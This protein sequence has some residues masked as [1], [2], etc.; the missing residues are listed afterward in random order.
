[1]NGFGLAVRLAR[2]ELRGGLRSG[3]R[4]FRIFIAC[5]ALGVAAIA[6]VGSIS[7][8]VVEG[9]RADARTLLGGDVELR[10]QHRAATAEQLAYLRDHSTELST[11]VRMR[12]MARPV[13]GVDSRA[14]VELK[15]VDAAYP[16]T[17][18]LQTDP[19][20]ERSD[21]LGRR[22]GV[23]GVAV[24]ANLL[25][26][27]GIERGAHLR[28]GEAEFEV[29]A[30]ITREPDRVASVIAFGPRALIAAAALADT[31]LVQPGSQIRY[32]YRLALA[33]ET[34]VSAWIET[35]KTAYPQAGWRIRG[36]DDAAPGVRRFIRRLTLFLTFVGLSTL[37]VGGIGV[38]NA[39]KSYLDGKT[40][41]IATLKCLGAPGRLVFAIYMLQIMGL[42]ALGI[43]AGLVFG[44]TAPVLAMEALSGLL[45]VQP[46]GGIFAVP[47]ILAAGFGVLTAATFA[48]WP[49]ARA[50]EIPA[51]N[52]FRAFI[53]PLEG[54]PRLPYMVTVFAGAAL[55]AAL[56]VGTASDV[57]SAL[58]FVGGAAATFAV[59]RLAAGGV[60]R[61]AARMPRPRGA[62]WRLALS[63][64][65]RP[66]TSTPATVVSLG[67]GLAVLVAVVLIE[68]N[69]TRQV[70]ERLPKE[71]P[72]LFF[73]D[74]QPH[75]VDT[76]DETVTGSEGASNYRRVPSLRGRIIRI[77]GVAV[78]D[79]KV[80]PESRW[81]V[82]GDRALTYAATPTKE[83][84][85]IAGKW[86][87]ADYS[88]P[89]II[90][91]DAGL[92]RGFGVG[93]GDKLAFNIL[94]REIEAEIVS[95]REIDWRSL[96]FDFAVIF[97]PGSLEG[98][99]HTHIAAVHGSPET[100][101]RIEKAV[102]DKYSNVSSIRVREALEA[103]SNILAGIGVA[104]RATASVTV[105]AGGLVLAG[106][107]AAARRRRIYDA[108][109][110]KVLG[111][112]RARILAAFLLEYGVL[113]L[114]TGLIAAV[115]GAITAWAVMVFL[116]QSE[117]IFFPLA[118]GVTVLACLAATLAVGFTGTWRALGQKAAPHLRNE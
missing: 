66:G 109:V 36:V 77:A 69:L 25:T 51:A 13:G 101:A 108:V 87:D 43:V 27:L 11:T 85:I 45:P 50:L 100:E 65:H 28:V 41:T 103:V 118:V 99:P 98:A 59:L 61:L 96:R 78:E 19:P 1:V 47:L 52:L 12:A 32:Y 117:F 74:V 22:D 5:L 81:A 114:C 72:A 16:L 20:S 18:S 14:L 40:A 102:T 116:M 63:N 24:D 6:G 97:A 71:A 67:L 55:M 9:L 4:G 26:K 62:E 39:T 23:W 33:A 21:L 56:T 42:A 15:A 76:F 8:S 79:A 106:A 48:L 49:L 110:F 54:R 84:K 91:L 90:S 35:I 86:W 104:V 112:T 73:I 38:G 3:F 113:G 30:V 29:R 83:S 17:G 37:L 75:Q 111:A 53:A 60:M 10:L 31:Q 2:R 58:W 107:V 95:L 82:R 93:L 89:P 7:S 80:A 115:I 57:R 68:G 105:L 92:A 94:G 34:E 46:K 88:G 64:L 44:A 70:D